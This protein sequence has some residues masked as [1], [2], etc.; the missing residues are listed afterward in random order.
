[1][2]IIHRDPLELYVGYV[3]ERIVK[4]PFANEVAKGVLSDL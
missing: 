4:T 2:N 1:M 3:V